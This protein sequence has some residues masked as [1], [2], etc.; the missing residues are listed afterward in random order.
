[1]LNAAGFL[2]VAQ[3]AVYGT[4]VPATKFIPLRS[5]TLETN[6]E[7]IERRVIRGDT[8][9]LV[10][11]VKGNMH[12][13][14]DIEIEVLDDTILYVLLA[15]RT[16]VVKT[17]TTPNFTYTFTPGNS[18]MPPKSISITVVRGDQVFGFTGCIVG[19]MEFTMDS[20]MLIC[21]T[22]VVGANEATA[23]TPTPTWGTTTP[24]G[25]GEY[26][27]EIPTGTP[28]ALF[29]SV[30]LGSY[31]LSIED[32]ATPEFR[33]RGDHG[34]EFARFGERSVSLSLQRDF[35]TRAEFDAYKAVTPQSINLLASHGVNNSINFLT[36]GVYKN[37]YA[38]GLASQGDLTRATIEYTC[39]RSGV[40]P[41]YT[42][43]VKTQEDIVVT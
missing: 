12:A 21:R 24:F 10:G 28:T 42:I 2:G 5:E 16:A 17:G 3:E 33:L 1:M 23:A 38:I 22:S 41:E 36:P 37:S 40:S 8:A 19:S 20:G 9:G 15:G 43:V 39:T 34:A 35:L 27:M 30:D 14:G 6:Q 18:A 7:L 25:P 31:S 4:F 13:A 32:N 26:T 11:I 29:E